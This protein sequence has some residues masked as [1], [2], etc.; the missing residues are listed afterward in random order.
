MTQPEYN[1]SHPNNRPAV[2]L[3]DTLVNMPFRYVL[4]RAC[5]GSNGPSQVE[6]SAR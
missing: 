6:G 3:E 4:S 1:F 5:A 2:R